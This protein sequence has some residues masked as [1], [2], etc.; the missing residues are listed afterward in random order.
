MDD[1]HLQRLLEKGQV[2]SYN[3]TALCEDQGQSSAYVKRY[4][5]QTMASSRG[6][7]TTHNLAERLN[8]LLDN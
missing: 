8:A 2:Y 7:P 5:G 6:K 3:V 4:I 1:G